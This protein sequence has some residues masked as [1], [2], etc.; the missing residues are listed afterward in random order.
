[1][2]FHGRRGARDEFGLG[3]EIFDGVM[4]HATVVS[5]CG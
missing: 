5:R 4:H 2:D 3:E 1:V